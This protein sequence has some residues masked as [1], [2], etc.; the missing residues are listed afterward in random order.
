MFV[1][2]C[3]YTYTYTYVCIYIYIHIYVYIYIY[4][5]KHHRYILIDSHPGWPPGGPAAGGPLRCRCPGAP[6][7]CGTGAAPGAAQGLRGAEA[8]H[9]P[10]ANGGA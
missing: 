5:Y 7:R 1:Y 2:I 9:G 4:T 8:R 10:A 3:I 6:R